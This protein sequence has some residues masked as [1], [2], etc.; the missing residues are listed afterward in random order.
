[1]KKLNFIILL[2]ILY[3]LSASGIIHPANNRLIVN[4]PTLKIIGDEKAVMIRIPP[5]PDFLNKSAKNISGAKVVVIY[6][7]FSEPAKAAFQDAVDIW[8]SLIISPVTIRIDAYWR[9]L[10]SDVLGSC[11][12]T[13]YYRGY[14]GMPFSDTFYPI[15]LAEK[16]AGESIND[17]SDFE[18]IANFNSSAN[19]YLGTDG[20]T[21][22]DKYDFVSVVLH[23]ICHG[24]GF[25]GSYSVNNGLGSWGWGNGSPFVYDR[26]IYDSYNV[27]LLNTSF[28]PNNSSELKAALT[29]QNVFFKGP[30][31]K[32]EFGKNISLYAPN[33]WNSG[34]SVYHIS[35]DY[36]SGNESLM[37][38][39]LNKGKSVHNPGVL[40]LSVLNEM[41]WKDLRIKH[42]PV[43]NSEIIGFVEITANIIPDFSTQV[44]NPKL[45]YS[46]DSSEYVEVN[47]SKNHVDTTLFKASIPIVKSG[48]IS[49]YITAGDKY[50]RSFKIPVTS[51]ETS[52]HFFIG[53]D[54]VPPMIKHYPN[55]FLMPGQ[56]SILIN[57]T[58]TDGFGV[59]TVWL[60]YSFNGLK[61]KNLALKRMKDSKYQLILDISVFDLQVGDSINY[62]I[63]ARDKS[64]AKNIQT[65]PVE[66]TVRMIVEAI[67]EFVESLENDFEVINNDFI[68]QGFEIIQPE[69]FLNNALHSLHPYEFAGENNSLEYLAQIRY[70][71]KISDKN[72]FM[73]FDEIVLVEPGEDGTVYG[74]ENFYDYVIVEASKDRGKNWI[75]LEPGWDSRRD[76]S[77]LKMYNQSIFGQFSQAV[78]NSSMFKNHLIDLLGSGKV[79]IG[80]EILIRFRLYSDP[81]ANGWGWAIDNLKIQTTGLASQ[82][83]KI[84]SEMKIYPNPVKGNTL[85]IDTKGETISQV[86]LYNLQGAMVF[87]TEKIE[88]NHLIELPAGIK[89]GFILYVTTEKRS[90]HLKIIVE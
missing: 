42:Q 10:T 22:A 83:L 73:S 31:V 26:Y 24:L 74:D 45:H 38:Y 60:E 29:S 19:W 20:N 37:T 41:G 8:A 59:D 86:T 50:G 27:S 66:G 51:P 11:G 7:G 56:D 70:P 85:T 89:G 32:T 34:S 58:V 23:E 62:K 75:P 6:N 63:M 80:D 43:I 69:G 77:W 47:L 76:D 13:N 52:Y 46:I 57:A 79:N 25:T 33:P 48:D 28:Y 81:Y 64:K 67:P 16:L 12:P 5:P 14:D 84:S 36:S 39:S 30:L 61:K 2:L 55:S 35:N 65:Y 4:G 3:S 82:Q 72:H 18:M 71:V 21:P 9:T 49:Y 88:S 78:G 87:R 17:T 1:M 44:I 15:S 68:L 53:A 90:G 54:T 40:A